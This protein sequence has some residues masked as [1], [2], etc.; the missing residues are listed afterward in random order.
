VVFGCQDV[1]RCL[2]GDLQLYILLV[3]N[4][5]T[6]HNACGWEFSVDSSYGS[7]KILWMFQGSLC[8]RMLDRGEISSTRSSFVCVCVKDILLPR[9]TLVSVV[10]PDADSTKLVTIAP[11]RR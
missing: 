1:P 10:F 8:M 4:F 11:C 3:T 5:E 6:D 9:L 2:S 7:V